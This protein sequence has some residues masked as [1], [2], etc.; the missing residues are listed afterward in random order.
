MPTKQEILKGLNKE[1]KSSVTMTEGYVRVLA[2][3]GSGKT[4]ALTSRYVYITSVLGISPKN[5]LCA[6]FT[7]KAAQEM[8]RRISTMTGLQ[9][10][11][12]ICTFHSFCV[13]FLKEECSAVNYPDKFPI[14][15]K[16]DSEK[17]FKEA[18]DKHR[19]NTKVV[20]IKKLWEHIR[21]KKSRDSEYICLLSS[22]SLDGLKDRLDKAKDQLDK[23]FYEYLY[24][25]RKSFA[26][27]FMDLIFFTLHI[28]R[29]RPDIC[30][31]WQERIQYVMVDEFQDVSQSQ[32]SL[33]EILSRKS[34]NLFIVGD[35]DQTIY[36]WRGAKVE[37]FLNFDKEHKE[38]KNIVMDTNYR[39]T[40]NILN[41]A[42][43][44]IRKNV[45]RLDKDLRP[46][47]PE[48]AA[49]EY[50]HAKA[51]KQEADWICKKIGEA[52]NLGKSY[53]DIAILYR[54]NSL[55]RI[56][57]ESLLKAKIPYT[58]FS[59]VAFYAR[60]EIKDI[61]AY[62]RLVCYGDDISFKRVVNEPKRGFGDKKID[63]E[64]YSESRGI[65]L[66]EGL[67]EKAKTTKYPDE[68]HSFIE[69][70]SR[71]KSKQKEISLTDL[72]AEILSDS[73]YEAMLRAS[74]DEDRLDNL[75][76]LKQ[77]VIE[78][79]ERDEEYTLDE[80]LSHIALFAN[81][82]SRYV[83]GSVKLMTVHTAKGLEFP[84]VFVYAMNEG[85]FPSSRSKTQDEIEE[86]R[87]LA[88]VA[89]T[90]AED[91]LYISD[92]ETKGNGAYTMYPSRFI[93]D[94]GK[95]NLKYLI[96]LRKELIDISTKVAKIF[97]P[98]QKIQEISAGSRISH[99]EWGEGT[100]IDED[101]DSYA[102]KFDSSGRKKNISK[103]HVSAQCKMIKLHPPSPPKRVVPYP[104]SIST[105]PHL[106]SLK[107]KIA[108]KSLSLEK[109]PISKAKSES[110]TA[111][112]TISIGE[113]SKHASSYPFTSIPD[114]EPQHSSSCLE[115]KNSGSESEGIK[116]KYVIIAVVIAILYFL[117]KS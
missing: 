48:S 8:K 64:A 34:G 110:V 3:A 7:N 69:L 89:F 107:I 44:L 65:S 50:F 60:K 58:I 18:I 12:Y 25:Q 74:G 42:N 73:G 10:L 105:D 27:D 49:V 94:T 70:V 16:E 13:S 5:I 81:S 101:S 2:G 14:I 72:V 40:P 62:L 52:R 56:L 117:L 95:E 28:L 99:P 114:E 51:Q 41:A 9:N 75:A 63:L 112:K 30:E 29:S 113:S 21:I 76:E 23:V 87:R 6:T 97:V 39:S 31:K 71:L 15:D 11:A 1:Q 33:A 103:H 78:F 93:F 98:A 109:S 80:F 91:M 84:I 106:D 53:S 57:E 104:R 96:K 36:S 77:S 17:I 59:G 32:Y 115:T 66:W 85:I 90:R 102:V 68:I 83:D 55:S 67:K 43:T 92:S 61:I 54:A 45:L 26:L 82:D 116:P 4:K 19:I 24:I 79:E 111:E 37:F 20:T 100:I 38:C 35:P 47:K 22:S 86:E 108:H 88:Y 46:T